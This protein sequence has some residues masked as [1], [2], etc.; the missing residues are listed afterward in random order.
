MPEE[1]KFKV[2]SSMTAVVESAPNMPIECDYHMHTPLC[3]H[4]AGPM[5][6]YVERAIELGLREIGFS[7]HCPLPNKLN[8]HVRM[9]E[10]E[11]DYYVGRVTDLQYEYRG[12]VDVRLGLEMDYLDGLE[13]YFE[14]LVRRHPWD[15]IIGSIH[16]LDAEC[17]THSWSRMLLNSPFEFYAQYFQQMRK[18][19]GTGLY[20][21]VAHLDLPKRSGLALNADEEVARTLQEIARAN[22]CVEINSSGYRHPELPNPEPYP[23]FPVIEQ[24]LALGIPLAVNSDAHAPEQVGLEFPRIERWLRQKGCERLARFERRKRESYPL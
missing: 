8:P 2:Q 1:A 14:Q 9:E 20:D 15:Y 13:G 23:G 3:K 11:L 12:K 6:A 18:L 7:D 17:R 19:V 21:I 10:K 22:V 24:A 16:H 5:E 4:A